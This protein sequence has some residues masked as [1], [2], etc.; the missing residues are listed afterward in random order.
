MLAQLGRRL[1]RIFLE[2]KMYKKILLAYN[3]SAAGQKAL[4]DSGEL[5]SWGKASLHL[6]AVM[7]LNLNSVVAE[8]I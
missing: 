1:A 6:V 7:P 8:G 4:L 3:G 5:A 2:A